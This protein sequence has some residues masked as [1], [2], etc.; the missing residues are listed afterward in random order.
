MANLH[1]ADFSQIITEE[2]EKIFNS[3]KDG[4]LFSDIR[5]ENE[6]EGNNVKKD[7]EERIKV[8]TPTKNSTQINGYRG[9]DKNGVP[10]R[11]ALNLDYDRLD[12]KYRDRVKALVQGKASPNQADIDDEASGVSTKG[13]QAF[14]KKM[15]NDNASYANA[16]GATQIN[17]R[18]VQPNKHKNPQFPTENKARVGDVFVESKNNRGLL[19]SGL[20]EDKTR[21]AF[22]DESGKKYSLSVDNF[23]KAVRENKM[24]KMDSEQINEWVSAIAPVVRAVG[25][26]VAKKVASKAAA[27]AATSAAIKT[28]SKIGT[29]ELLKKGAKEIG[30]A[31][32]ANAALSAGEKIAKKMEEEPNKDGKKERKR[33]FLKRTAKEIA[34]DSLKMT[35]QKVADKINGSDTAK[36]ESVQSKMK[37]LKFNKTSF[38]SETHVT[39]LIPEQYKTP[40]NKFMMI[41]KN[42]NEYLI[43]CNKSNTPVI[44]E[45]KNMVQGKADFERM[46]QLWEYDTRKAVGKSTINEVKAQKDLQAKAHKLM[47]KKPVK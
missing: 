42:G 28:G 21:V 8:S 27:K 35:G 18:I 44:L 2:V 19:L 40:G 13:N 4:K 7:A 10:G 30:G 29:K 11:N 45:Y 17:D 33:D 32:A 24:S 3:S 25:G 6:K 22:V 43:E 20:N 12:D 1:I 14:Y 5:S 41:D 36:N 31:V 37:R 16:L 23:R 9:E 47:E 15:Q 39:S 38:I 26:A 34:N 46:K